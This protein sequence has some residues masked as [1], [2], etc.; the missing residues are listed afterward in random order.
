MSFF[1]RRRALRN[2]LMLSASTLIPQHA[3]AASRRS[4]GRETTLV[5]GAGVAGLAAARTL[6]AAGQDV[7]VLDGRE[8]IGGR[9]W[10]DR[11][12]G[13]VPVDLGA[14]WI[15]G[16]RFNPVA[17]LAKEFKLPTV[18]FD[19]DT[20]SD[21][22][23]SR[24]YNAD[25]RPVPAA[26]SRQLSDD[27]E[28]VEEHLS[29]LAEKASP[30]LAAGTALREVLGASGMSEERRESVF[31][32]QSRMVEDDF[33]AGIDEI[34]AWGLDEGEEF[35]GHEVVFPQGYGQLVDRLAQGLDVRL[36]HAI[37]R[38]EHGGERVRVYTERD[39]LEAKRVIVTLPLG[40]L[41]AR[42]VK[43]T[44]E[45]PAEKIGAI[46]RLGMGVYDKLYLRF[47]SVFWDDVHVISQQG[48][49]HGMWA[50][51]YALQ[52]VV[53]APILCAL[54]GGD[55][56][57][58]IEGM[59]DDEIVRDAMER[60]TSIYGARVQ[61]PIGHRVTRWA[62]DPFARGSYSFAAVGSRRGDRQ[63]LA[64]PIDDHLYFAGEATHEDYSGT[65]H[66]ALLSGWREARRILG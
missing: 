16:V 39:V 32:L 40:V 65:V 52:H 49:R 37:T 19:A 21:T 43:F 64:A 57:R 63:L 62:S 27:Q 46:D 38:I 47:P 15:H 23:A 66:G 33:G 9:I 22:A 18:V 41:K 56:A 31:E 30:T 59:T 35:G 7:I 8:R 11:T 61:Q 54:N 55:V 44:P 10:T 29:K 58:R 51:W 14:S 2:A 24:L 13:D 48:N 42:A 53:H 1:M 36:G 17:R 5:I 20:L 12:W 28:H 45:L 3:S 25:G 26:Q 34:A 60:L 50:N 6:R 4:S